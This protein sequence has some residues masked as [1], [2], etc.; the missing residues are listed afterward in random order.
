[1]QRSSNEPW[2]GEA[3]RNQ[4]FAVEET[5]V[6]VTL[7][8]SDVPDAIKPKDRPVWMTESTVVS[9]DPNATESAD[10]ILQ[11]AALASTQSTVTVGGATGSGSASA[12]HRRD[13]EDIMQVLL[14]HEKQ[15]GKNTVAQNAVKGLGTAANSSE[16]SDDEQEIENAVIRKCCFLLYIVKLKII[17][18]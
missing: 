16:S 17:I 15:Q 10:S 18:F 4:G 11:K 5:R 1:M 6:D 14:Q 9:N 8:G 13:N 12:R 3:T 7:D 2:S